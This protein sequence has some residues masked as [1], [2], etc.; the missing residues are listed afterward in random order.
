MSKKDANNRYQTPPRPRQTSSNIYQTPLV[1]EGLNTSNTNTDEFATPKR[2]S[3]AK[4]NTSGRLGTPRKTPYEMVRDA[5]GATTKMSEWRSEKKEVRPIAEDSNLLKP[6]E[7]NRS[8][9]PN[10]ISPRSILPIT[11]TNVTIDVNGTISYFRQRAFE[12]LQREENP[13]RPK[14]GNNKFLQEAEDYLYSIA[15]PAR[16]GKV[17]KINELSEQ[18]A[19]IEEFLRANPKNDSNSD[20]YLSERDRKRKEDISAKEVTKNKIHNKIKAIRRDLVDDYFNNQSLEG[21]DEQTLYKAARISEWLESVLYSYNPEVQQK[22]NERMIGFSPLFSQQESLTTEE[23]LGMWQ[24]YEKLIISKLGANN[25]SRNEEIAK[26][27]TSKVLELVKQPI[28]DFFIL[29]ER[30]EYEKH[31]AVAA[32]KRRMRQSIR[33]LSKNGEEINQLKQKL[34][35]TV[36]SYVTDNKYEKKHI[37]LLNRELELFFGQVFNLDK[38]IFAISDSQRKNNF[39]V[40]RPFFGER[41]DSLF[42]FEDKDR[43]ENW[44]KELKNKESNLL[45]KLAD[46][47]DNIDDELKNL[48]ESFIISKYV[49]VTRGHSDFESLVVAEVILNFINK[50]N[51]IAQNTESALNNFSDDKVKEKYQFL[52]RNFNSKA[53]ITGVI[54]ASDVEIGQARSYLTPSKTT[55]TTPSTNRRIITPG[56]A[57]TP[58]TKIKVHLNDSENFKDNLRQLVHPYITEEATRQAQREYFDVV[59]SLPLI[60]SVLNLLREQ[61]KLAKISSDAYQVVDEG[62]LKEVSENNESIEYLKDFYMRYRQSEHRLDNSIKNFAV[63]S[64]NEKKIQ[65]ERAEYIR[66]FVEDQILRTTK[67][68]EYLESQTEEAKAFT[69]KRLLVINSIQ[70]TKNKLTK[71]LRGD[72]HFV[73][74]FL[75]QSN[76]E[77]SKKIF[78]YLVCD[79]SSEQVNLASLNELLKKQEDLTS[80]SHTIIEVEGKIVEFLNK[81]AELEAQQ[82]K[83]KLEDAAVLEKLKILIR[84]LEEGLESIK[85]QTVEKLKKIQ[86]SLNEEEGLSSAE[87]LAV[88]TNALKQDEGGEEKEEN[89]LEELKN[90]TRNVF[91]SLNSGKDIQRIVDDTLNIIVSP[92]VSDLGERKELLTKTHQDLRKLYDQIAEKWN[93]ISADIVNAKELK[94][95]EEEE[96]LLNE[97]LKKEEEIRKKIQG[98]KDYKVVLEEGIKQIKTNYLVE[99]AT[100]RFGI[101]KKHY[102]L[103]A[104][105]YTSDQKA[106][107]GIGLIKKAIEKE[108][109][110][111]GLIKSN[112]GNAYTT[113]IKQKT[114]AKSILTP[115]KALKG[116]PLKEQ[117]EIFKKA[118]WV[119][120]VWIDEVEIQIVDVLIESFEPKNQSQSYKETA[121]NKIQ[122]LRQK[123]EEFIIEFNRIGGTKFQELMDLGQHIQGLEEDLLKLQQNIKNELANQTPLKFERGRLTHDSEEDDETIYSRKTPS[124][125][126]KIRAIVN[127]L[128]SEHKKSF[129]GLVWNELKGDTCFSKQE[130]Q[131]ITTDR[132]IREALILRRVMKIALTQ[133]DVEEFKESYLQDITRLD[134]LLLSLIKEEI[135][136]AVSR[137]GLNEKWKSK[138]NQAAHFRKLFEASLTALDELEK[139]KDFT[140]EQFFQLQD[141]TIKALAVHIHQFVEDDKD[142]VLDADMEKLFSQLEKAKDLKKASSILMKIS[143]R[144]SEQV[145]NLITTILNNENFVRLTETKDSQN[146]DDSGM[147]LTDYSDDFERLPGKSRS[148]SRPGSR[149]PKDVDPRPNSGKSGKSGTTDYYSDDDF[150]EDSRAGSRKSSRGNLRSGGDLMERFIQSVVSQL[151][152][153]DRKE[154]E[155]FIAGKGKNLSEEEKIKELEILNKLVSQGIKQNKPNGSYTEEVQQNIDDAL[156]A[157]SLMKRIKDKYREKYI[158]FKLTEAQIEFLKRAK[159]GARHKA[160]MSVLKQIIEEEERYEDEDKDKELIKD[161]TKLYSAAVSDKIKNEYSEEELSEEEEKLLKDIEKQESLDDLSDEVNKFK[162]KRKDKDK[163]S[164]K[165]VSFWGDLLKDERDISRKNSFTS[166]YDDE[167]YPESR[168]DTAYSDKFDQESRPG[169]SAYSDDSNWRSRATTPENLISQIVDKLDEEDRSEYNKSSKAGKGQSHLEQLLTLRH[170]LDKGLK[171]NKRGIYTKSTLDRIEEEI[172]EELKKEVLDNNLSEQQ[173]K[174]IKNSKN[175][176]AFCSDLKAIIEEKSNRYGEDDDLVQKL[177]GILAR[178]IVVEIDSEYGSKLNGPQ[179]KQLAEIARIKNLKGLKQ[180]VVQF[181]ETITLIEE[182]ETESVSDDEEEKSNS[183]KSKVKNIIKNIIKDLSPEKERDISIRGTGG[184]G[185]FTGRDYELSESED[186]ND[187]FGNNVTFYDDGE[188]KFDEDLYA[189]IKKLKKEIESLQKQILE[190]TSNNEV[191]T[192]NYGAEIANLR[193]LLEQKNKEGKNKTESEEDIKGLIGQIADLESKLTKKNKEYQTL[194]QQQQEELNKAKNEFLSKEKEHQEYK[195]T[196]AH[197]INQLIET[198]YEIETNGSAK[199]LQNKVYLDQQQQ[200]QNKITELNQDLN[201]KDKLQKK[202]L[203]SLQERIAQQEKEKRDLESRLKSLQGKISN[204]T[205]GN[206]DWS[207]EINSLT[208]QLEKKEQE[209]Q[210]LQNGLSASQRNHQDEINVAISR[211]EIL[212]QEKEKILSNLEQEKQSRDEQIQELEEQLSEQN[213]AFDGLQTEFIKYQKN[214]ESLTREISEQETIINNL[215]G[216]IENFGNKNNQESLEKEIADLREIISKLEKNR[217]GANDVEYEV[218]DSRPEMAKIEF[219]DQIKFENKKF[220]EIQG[221]RLTV[222]KP[223]LKGFKQDYGDKFNFAANREFAEKIDDEKEEFINDIIEYSYGHAGLEKKDASVAILLAIKYGRLSILRD[224]EEKATAWQKPIKDDLRKIVGEGF[225]DEALEE[226][227]SKIIDFSATF[228]A[229]AKEN[230]LY[231]GSEKKL[232]K[233]KNLEELPGFRLKR[234]S[235][236]YSRDLWDENNLQ[237]WQEICDE[238][239]LTSGKLATVV[240]GYPPTETGIRS[241]SKSLSSRDSRSLE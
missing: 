104:G 134:E 68:I 23:Q 122:N 75:N 196:I 67:K 240:D 195:A 186:E 219:D 37:I 51:L 60:T 110:S 30:A 197:K 235:V 160:T 241:G 137:S 55:P 166:K 233:V 19:E 80:A 40:P 191:I 206:K 159:I 164:R 182:E 125:W 127:S 153:K 50:I 119:L 87:K 135:K 163:K 109:F 188:E 204:P 231:T 39:L 27:K 86:D 74:A 96:R 35:E 69:A 176:A 88:V 236:N 187:D 129:K 108:R 203:E 102:E 116:T 132:I 62:L 118:G 18:F 146:I 49:E 63:E 169:T 222:F 228:T 145:K 99:S 106:E 32:E 22:I 178:T 17:E 65:L 131:N 177:T 54:P 64:F 185:G 223:K 171:K 227:F 79:S 92:R 149:S 78:N 111:E 218:I 189:Q 70:D 46:L 42:G 7:K 89:S 117:P 66:R 224:D 72:R 212:E 112:D 100:G 123:Q 93:K 45:N 133:D 162:E 12:L 95:K 200:L 192:S 175:I 139:D 168:P 84:E 167:F 21:S 225:E 198:N 28:R 213:R 47:Y 71:N 165:R 208:Q 140:D 2:P 10:K 207:D 194:Y 83:K 77:K 94:K 15:E 81:K 221:E 181:N 36:F 53:I 144:S 170:Y 91:I 48:F 9:T 238:L 105:E 103:I 154:Y 113:P 216:L 210:N 143:D 201:A 14:I 214:Y 215:R 161:L 234:L 85:S 114:P 232:E 147:D 124:N 217:N 20:K 193:Y 25:S 29:K 130:N 199:L 150:N 126:Q 73:L 226:L 34:S 152:E 5:A 101:E 58:N 148:S 157:D 61:E 57:N 184:D 138:I 98:Y 174:K 76:D 43:N 41:F 11:R 205:E 142:T 151:D 38:S 229:I 209:I 52:I 121:I 90:K 31:S 107:T 141:L 158:K 120:K 44:K 237:E 1:S 155:N 115:F 16:P 97:R 82:E 59:K 33:N 128:Q 24:K 3:T 13:T 220:L 8:G 180:K 136:E 6:Q 230:G 239:G 56:L 190:I 173:S 183:S 211:L 4:K 172:L 26:G 179:Q 156:R 202:N